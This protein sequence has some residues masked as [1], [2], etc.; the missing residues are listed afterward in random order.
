[1]RKILSIL[2]LLLC[3]NCKETPKT[4]VEIDSPKWHATLEALEQSDTPGDSLLLVNYNTALKNYTSD[5]N[6]TNTI[7]LGRRIAYTGAFNEAIAIYTKG[8]EQFPEDARLYRHRGHRY[9]S[10]REFEKALIDLNTATR[11]IRNTDDQIE[12]D[13]VPNRLNRPIST[14]HTNIWYHFGLTYYLR[15]ELRRAKVA[16]TNC[17]DA[18]TNDDNIVSASHWLYMIHRRMGDQEAA[19]AILEPIEKEMTIIENEAY[20]Q[21]LLFY[22]GLISEDELK[23]NA[24]LGSS[25]AVQY[26]LANWYHYN[27]D[28]DKAQSMYKEI[29]ANGYASSFGYIAAEQ[30]LK[31]FF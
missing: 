17:L 25:E 26:G 6:V 21:L 28:K 24:S 4:P 30:D 19:D 22:K 31:R 8:L 16:F 3:L 1:M 13:G 20:H 9:I 14:L 12:P 7:W 18:S 2:V 27:G 29:V 23:G 11:L 15:N 10:T 5:P